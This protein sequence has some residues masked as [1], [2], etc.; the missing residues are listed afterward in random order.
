[1]Q[2]NRAAMTTPPDDFAERVAIVTGG[3]RGI[4]LATVEELAARGAR[5]LFCGRDEAT[6][7]AAEAKL[8]QRGAQ[9]RF[10]AADIGRED[11]VEALV[12]RCVEELGPPHV[13]VNNA[14]VNANFDAE[15]MTEDEWDRFFA[16]DLKSSWL[17][18]KHV[19]AHM[20]AASGG[21]IVN[22]SSIHGLVTLEGFFPYAAAKSGLIGLTRSLALDYGRYG[23]RVN[24]LC[25][26]FTRT[27]LVSGADDANIAPEREARLA[28]GVALGRIGEP[29]EVARTI[30]FLASDAASYVTG[31]TL[32]VDGGLTARRSGGAYAGE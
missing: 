26:G 2:R 21:A 17:T 28:A 32:L 6:G 25:P 3:S 13:L 10:A 14:G 16:I 20:R 1:M 12:A 31:A 7:R 11:D 8:A 5:V 15:A 4:G 18:A 22:V 23:I 27:R 9:V 30:A 19:L 29:D 24:C